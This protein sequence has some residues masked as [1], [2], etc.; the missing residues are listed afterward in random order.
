MYQIS[1]P[2]S[3]PDQAKTYGSDPQHFCQ[4]AI[5]FVNN[6]TRYMVLTGSVYSGANHYY[7][8]HKVIGT[9]TRTKST[10]KYL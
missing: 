9:L 1:L 6:I 10:T 4:L 2:R 3:D 5:A 7:M 8:A